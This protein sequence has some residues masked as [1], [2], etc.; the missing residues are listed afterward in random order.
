MTEGI[1][2]RR[3]FLQAGVG[4]VASLWACRIGYAAAERRKPN[5][6]LILADDLGYGDIGC[7][8]NTA[9]KTPNLDALA[10]NGVRFT[11]FH[12]NGP[13]CSPTRA[14]FLTGRYQQRSG[15][16][17]V[18]TAETHRDTGMP[19]GEVTF[20]EMLA[21]A[22][23][24]TALFGKWHLGYPVAFNPVRQGF[25]TFRGYVSGNV[26]YH[27]HI[28]MAGEIDWW[29][30]DTLVAEEGYVTDLVSDHGVRFVE[31]H[32]DG[33]FCL[34]LAH[35]APHFPYQGRND[36]ADRTPGNPHPTQGSRKDKPGAYT[37]MIEALDEGVGRI[38]DAIRRSG[39]EENTLIFFCSD[40]GATKLGS[41]DPLKG[42]K[43][44]L[45][46][47][48]HRVPA[49][50]CW[51]GQIEP[52][53]S[54]ATLMTMDLFPTMAALA[55][56]ELPADR[57]L[58]GTDLSGHLL[59]R[60]ALPERTLFWRFQRRVAVRRGPWKLVGDKSVE[61]P[62]R[63]DPVRLY[64]LDE[65]VGEVRDL[66]GD[67]PDVLASLTSAYWNWEREVTEGVTMLT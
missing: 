48:G 49:I 35:E 46:E 63:L 22:G 8:G 27:S 13:V 38:V 60:E 17:G 20:A 36:K 11:D 10:A 47:G 41:N 33:P 30:D 58:D 19:L 5:F 51:P 7:Y 42:N 16:D 67:Y 37:E 1:C 18:F 50:A 3:R 40:N 53:V 31:A 6:V 65:D 66:A 56:A 29:R 12:S 32:A 57:P 52:G 61:N 43:G 28:D 59:R 54:H 4:A 14:A 9:I 62:E 44:G 24:Q 34:Y 21:A 45:W 23:Y 55:G 2:N 64:N 25:G 15:L 39:L 26:D